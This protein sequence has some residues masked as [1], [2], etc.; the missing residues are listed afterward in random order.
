MSVINGFVD[1]T[2]HNDAG[3]YHMTQCVQCGE[4]AGT[5]RNPGL[6]RGFK[7]DHRKRC[8]VSGSERAAPCNKPGCLHCNP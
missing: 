1:T 8:V 3:T 5:C 7:D 4:R 2:S 6:L